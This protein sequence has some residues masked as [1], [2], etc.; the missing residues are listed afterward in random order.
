MSHQLLD[1]D[2]RHPRLGTVDAE[3]VA[4]VVDPHE[5]VEFFAGQP[6]D[7]EVIP[8]SGFVDPAS[9]ERWTGSWRLPTFFSGDGIPP[10][11]YLWPAESFRPLPGTFRVGIVWQGNILHQPY[12]ATR[13]AHWAPVLA[14]PGCSFYSLQIG[15]PSNQIAECGARVYDLSPELTSWTKTAAAIAELDLII[16][17]DTAVTNL[18]GGLG[19]PVWLCLSASPDWRWMLERR[20]TPWYPSARLFRQPHAGNWAP[21][22]DEVAAELRQ[23]VSPEG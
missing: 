1:P 3:G 17:V 13:L 8:S 19:R 11:P 5:L 7:A 10:A 22:F 18:A 23:L 20:D 2:Q 15:E 4:Q 6:W 12:R 9:F 21:V 16:G 14:V